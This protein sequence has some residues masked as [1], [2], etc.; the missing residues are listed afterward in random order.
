MRASVFKLGVVLL[1]TSLLGWLL[2][3]FLIAD[4]STMSYALI[5][6]LVVSGTGGALMFFGRLA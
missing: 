1:A 2:D 4:Q 5:W 3:F 6:C